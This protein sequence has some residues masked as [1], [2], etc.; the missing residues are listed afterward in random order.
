MI[1]KC[2]N[3]DWLWTQGLVSCM[4]GRDCWV[5]LGGNSKQ[6][7]PTGA[8][9][10]SQHYRT[11]R[12]LQDPCR[13]SSCSTMPSFQYCKGSRWGLCFFH[14]YISNFSPKEMRV[15]KYRGYHIP[16]QFFPDGKSCG[17]NCRVYLSCCMDA[18]AGDAHRAARG[19]MKYPHGIAEYPPALQDL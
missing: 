14:L 7:F 8:L 16:F 9:W 6:K 11:D 4:V 1:N 13:L 10:S 19:T 5:L 12:S 2:D 17:A 3:K 18:H 15:H